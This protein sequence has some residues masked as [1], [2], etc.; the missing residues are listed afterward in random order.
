MWH[1]DSGRRGTI[2]GRPAAYRVGIPLGK[3]AAPADVANAVVF[4]LSDDAGHITLHDLTVDG[5]AGLGA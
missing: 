1:D 2:E 3:L 4:L 5:G